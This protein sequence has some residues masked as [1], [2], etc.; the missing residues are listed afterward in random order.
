M[1]GQEDEEEPEDIE[2]DEGGFGEIEEG[3]WLVNLG[4][5]EDFHGD[6]DGGPEE[7]RIDEAPG[8]TLEELGGAVFLLAF[9]GLIASQNEE[10]RHMEGVDE[11]VERGAITEEGVGLVEAFSHVAEHHQHDA[12]G[13]GDIEGGVSGGR[14]FLKIVYGLKVLLILINL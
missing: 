13:F 4:A 1:H 2:G 8:F 6:E 10:Y 7:V 11:E 12:E 3:G 5:G 14:H 9:V